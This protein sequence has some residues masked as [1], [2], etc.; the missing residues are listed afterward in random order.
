MEKLRCQKVL[1]AIV[2]EKRA[3][4]G[5]RVSEPLSPH[6]QVEIILTH[7]EVL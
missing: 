6:T 2:R 7:H 5:V 3:L 1:N 4:L